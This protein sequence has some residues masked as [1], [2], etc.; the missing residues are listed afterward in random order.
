VCLCRKCPSNP[1]HSQHKRR[2]SPRPWLVLEDRHNA[3][4][5]T[6][7]VENDA[8]VAE[9]LVNLTGRTTKQGL[10]L[11]PRRRVGLLVGDIGRDGG[12]WE[13]PDLDRGISPLKGVNTA[14]NRVEVIAVRERV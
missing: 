12:P 2:R 4:S 8:H 13:V 14:S 1:T 9:E 6:Y 11:A 5:M 3:C 10:G 7:H